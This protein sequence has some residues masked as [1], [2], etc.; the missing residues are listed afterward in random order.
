[1]K[2]RNN[3]EVISGH[4]FSGNHKVGD[5]LFTYSRQ[6]YINVTFNRPYWMQSF[7]NSKQ[8]CSICHL[9]LNKMLFSAPFSIFI[10]YKHWNYCGISG[11]LD[12]NPQM[13]AVCCVGLKVATNLHQEQCWWLSHGCS[14]PS[15]SPRARWVKVKGQADTNLYAQ[16]TWARN[17]LNHSCYGR[18]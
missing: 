13:S 16:N 6:F 2:S 14:H 8:F 5:Y 9:S 18:E 15:H 4:C 7:T 11:K 10:L 3:S 12:Q 17:S 1:M